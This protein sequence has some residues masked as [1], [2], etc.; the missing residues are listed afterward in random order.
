MRPLVFAALLAAL[1][2]CVSALRP[3]M[4][5]AYHRPF[6]S[7]AI[8]FYD[9]FYSDAL[10]REGYPVPSQPPVIVLQSVPAAAPVP[11]RPSVPTQ[12]LMIELQGDRYVRISGEET[13][14]ADIKQVDP[15]TPTQ[16]SVSRRSGTRSIIAAQSV[17]TQQLAPAIL[18]F[19]DG[20]RQEVI[21]YTIAEGI[22]Y[23]R[24]DYYTDGY[25]NNKIALSSL[26]LPDTITANQS[27]GIK[28]QL[29][30]APNEVIVR[31]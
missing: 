15:T 23:T 29:P 9:P 8:F 26:N 5:G 7:P 24:A 12:P 2:P 30:T 6:H 14:T 3:G 31:P 20:R 27:R 25:W 21:E 28:F 19:R 10:S 17:A 4:G 13:S 22:L 16:A 18:V 11:D 1:A